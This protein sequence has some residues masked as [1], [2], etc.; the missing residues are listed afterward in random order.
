FMDRLNARSAELMLTQT[1][2]PEIGVCIRYVV[3]QPGLR[4]HHVIKAFKIVKECAEETL[5]AQ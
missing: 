5:Q 3:G 1:V 4:E 2:L